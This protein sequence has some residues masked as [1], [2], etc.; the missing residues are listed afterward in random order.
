M[1]AD[2][3]RN[4]TLH[5]F[6]AIVN[7]FAACM[8]GADV[9]YGPGNVPAGCTLSLNRAGR[10]PADFDGDQDVDQDDFGVLQ[11]C[12]SGA[13]NPADVGCMK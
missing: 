8:T 13:G 3:C 4:K 10:L 9:P 12:L 11:R 5:P 6:S 1:H 7:A 2:E